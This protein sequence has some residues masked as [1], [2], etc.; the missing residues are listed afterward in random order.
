MGGSAAGAEQARAR[1]RESPTV[2]EQC[3]SI[4]IVFI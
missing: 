2:V 3:E 4:R 1:N